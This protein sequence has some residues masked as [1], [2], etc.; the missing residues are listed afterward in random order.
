MLAAVNEEALFDL[1]VRLLLE[2]LE[3]WALSLMSIWT[4]VSSMIA[5]ICLPEGPMIVPILL[6]LTWMVS[7]RGA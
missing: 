5:R 1:E 7:M 3:V 4:P 6:G 2:A